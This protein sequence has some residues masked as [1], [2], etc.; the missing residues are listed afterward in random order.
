MFVSFS[1]K[2]FL[3]DVCFFVRNDLY[4]AVYI[5]SALRRRQISAC[6]A[7][8]SWCFKI[9]L[10]A[11][12]NLIFCSGRKPGCVILHFICSLCRWCCLRLDGTPQCYK[13]IWLIWDWQLFLVDNLNLQL[14]W[15]LCFVSHCLCHR[16]SCL[17]ATFPVHH[18]SGTMQLSPREKLRERCGM[19]GSVFPLL[20][21]A[22]LVV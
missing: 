8:F 17:R 20:F 4:Y 10:F 5:L 18:L 14:S 19:S 1:P 16:P 15:S 12:I 11:K 6:S 3:L 9:Q 2:I 7:W 21:S 13:D 22:R